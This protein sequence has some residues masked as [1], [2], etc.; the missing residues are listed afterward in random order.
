[1]MLL[2]RLAAKI[3][4]IKYEPQVLFEFIRKICVGSY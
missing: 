2:V 4:L 1:M 3:E